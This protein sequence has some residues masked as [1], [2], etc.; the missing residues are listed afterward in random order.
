MSSFRGN[1]WEVDL[2][3][4]W[5]GEHTEE[6]TTIY[7][8]D[9]V[10]ALQI[11]SYSKNDSVTE[12]DLMDLAQEHIDTGAKPVKAEAGAFEGFTFAFG[13]DGEFWQFW[14]VARDNIALL[15]TYNCNEADLGPE[16]E[17]A[18]SIVASLKA[19]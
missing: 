12:S 14:Y 17:H 19:T 7:H 3:P 4:D 1:S 10:G 5:I 13:I 9:G 2:L 18:K 8:P 16:R 6:C 11:S 15:I